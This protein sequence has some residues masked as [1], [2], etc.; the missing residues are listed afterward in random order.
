MLPDRGLGLTQ[1]PQQLLPPGTAEAV[2]GAGVREACVML[3]ADRKGPMR[4]E[5]Q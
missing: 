3:R 2:D 4:E 1:A 5:W